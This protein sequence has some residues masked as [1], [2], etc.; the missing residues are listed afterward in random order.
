MRTQEIFSAAIIF[1]SDKPES[2]PP[3][4]IQ[5]AGGYLFLFI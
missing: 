2:K 3:A 5:Y 4:Y 1:Y